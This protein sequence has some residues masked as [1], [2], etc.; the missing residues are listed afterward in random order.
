VCEF[1]NYYIMWEVIFVSIKR[2][3]FK[4][5]SRLAAIVALFST[6]YALKDNCPSVHP[7][8]TLEIPANASASDILCAAT[9]LWPTETQIH[10]QKNEMIGFTHFGPNTFTGLESKLNDICGRNDARMSANTIFQLEQEMRIRTY[11]SLANS[12]Q[13]NGHKLLSKQGSKECC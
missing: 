4:M 9:K 3:S 1:R 12:I 8:W 5:V 2:I 7:N 10:E 6:A 13:R 11:F